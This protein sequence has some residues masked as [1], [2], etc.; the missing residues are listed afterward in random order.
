MCL[1]ITILKEVILYLIT[2]MMKGIFNLSVESGGVFCVSHLILYFWEGWIGRDHFL[3]LVSV[4]GTA[5][6][7]VSLLVNP[8]NSSKTSKFVTHCLQCFWQLCFLPARMVGGW[9]CGP[10]INKPP[11]MGNVSFCLEPK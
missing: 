11:R 4:S 2:S 3:V 1:C 6:G 8:G 10:W 9:S 5:S 7:S